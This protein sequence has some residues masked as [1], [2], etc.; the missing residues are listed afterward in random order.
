MRIAFA[1]SGVELGEHEPDELRRIVAQYFAGIEEAGAQHHRPEDIGQPV[2][3]ALAGNP[4]LGD[5][6]TADRDLGD[7]AGIE[8]IKGRVGSHRSPPKGSL[9]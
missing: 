7:L 4:Q 9:P 6:D 5:V 2:D 8:R 3:L 1:V